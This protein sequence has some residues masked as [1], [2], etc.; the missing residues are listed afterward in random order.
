MNTTDLAAALDKFAAADLR[1]AKREG[2]MMVGQTKLGTVSLSHEGGV[3]TLT[4]QGLD[5]KVLASGKPAAV[6]P[7]LAA[8]YS[9]QVAS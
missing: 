9:V 5:A 2:Y 6:R 1:A 8:L 4:T 7:V 3:Y